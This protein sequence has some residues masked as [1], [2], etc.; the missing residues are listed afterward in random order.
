M[1]L[2]NSRHVAITH[3]GGLL[4]GGS[5]SELVLDLRTL[6]DQSRSYMPYYSLECMTPCFCVFCFLCK[7]KMRDLQ[8]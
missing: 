8:V 5:R 6:V 2:A 3:P 4:G 7:S 1:S